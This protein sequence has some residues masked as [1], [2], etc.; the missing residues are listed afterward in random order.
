MGEMPPFDPHAI[1]RQVADLGHKLTMELLADTQ[2]IYRPFHQT[3]P[4]PGIPVARDLR[5]G[6]N[7][8]HRLDVFAEPLDGAAK[9]PALIFVHGGG[10]VGGDKSRPGSP[11][12]DNVGLWAA[13][14]GWVGI[15][16]TYRLA[17]DHQWPAGTDDVEAAVA[18]VRANAADHGIDTGRIYVLGQSAGASHVAGYVARTAETGRE[19]EIAGA[20]LASGVYD[21]TVERKGGGASAY[22]GEDPA[23]YPERSP[24]NGLGGADIALVLAC[25]E[26]DPSFF[27]DQTLRAA[28]EI[29][30]ARRR[31]PR[32][33]V[34]PSHNHL[35][36]MLHLGLPG[37]RLGAEILDL[38]AS[39]QSQPVA[40]AEELTAAG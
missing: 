26:Y 31:L 39:L 27:Q 37:D 33:V 35:S 2:A 9:R 19:P 8:R 23:L 13:R 40:Q 10:F 30:Q 12:Y 29:F 20:I 22:Y 25:A 4:D 6:P 16:M 38:D 14:Q 28:R 17:P 3:E 18:W 15:T 21:L 5:Y 1:G 24:I 11:F 36:G 7:E 34:M 32:F